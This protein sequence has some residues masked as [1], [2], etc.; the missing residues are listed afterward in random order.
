MKKKGII[1]L[2]LVI[3]QGCFVYAQDINEYI[4]RA[5]AYMDRSMFSQ[6]IALYSEALEK[7]DD[8]RLLTGRGNALLMT[9]KTKEAINDFNRANILKPG[10]GYM[11]LARAFALKKDIGNTVANLQ[12]HLESD[13]RMPR[14]EI[15]L[16]KHFSFLENRAEWRQLW[17][18]K[19]HTRLEEAVNEIEYYVSTGKLK[20]AEGVFVL[21]KDVYREQPEIL[22][23]HGLIESAKNNSSEALQYL[24]KAVADG[25]TDYSAWKL[26]IELLQING[27]Y[28]GAANECDR[29]LSNY[30]EQ[31]E[32]IFMKSE[33]L[34]KANDRDRAM[35]EAEKYLFLYPDDE[36]ANRQA[37]L[38]AGEKGEYNKALRY[39]SKNTDNFPG[40]SQCFTDRANIYLKL[41]SWDAAVYDY[42]MALDLWP[43]NGDAY[44][45]K[46]VAL[47]NTG[48]TEEACH[49]FRM[50]LR[51]GNRKASGMISKHCIR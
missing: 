50:A 30:P 42:S 21:V 24:V 44:Y 36:K 6:A 51:Y 12:Y 37:G 14:R 26:Y 40:N 23:L 1:L 7:H 32:L 47:I 28:I 18:T 8:Y 3:I 13:F 48:K 45:N 11:G 16:D 9:G 15:L 25:N 17:K 22:Y 31:T 2:I 4:T 20:E 38:I 46:G 35:E 39:F 34:R 43:R 5:K 33:N 27:N 10:S 19:W 29:A 49:D 41:K